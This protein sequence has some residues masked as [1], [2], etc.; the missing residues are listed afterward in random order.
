[1]KN[2][3]RFAALMLALCMLLTACFAFAEDTTATP[4]EDPV[5]VTINGDPIA[6]AEIDATMQILFNNSY[7]SSMTDYQAGVA[8]IV[9][10]YVI[11]KKIAELGLDQYTDE[12]KAA[13]TATAQAEWDAAID[14]Y[15]AYYLSEDTEA[16]RAELAAAANEYYTGQG[17]SVEILAEQAE[18]IAT[19]DKLEAYLKEGKDISVTDDEI[20][21]T[22]EMY[23]AY[24]KESYENNVTM[25]EYYTTYMGQPS[26]YIPAG[27]RGVTQILLDVDDAILADY[28]DKLA[29]YE[30]S[31]SAATAEATA[32][33]DATAE[34]VVAVTLEDVEAAKLAVLESVKEQIDAIQTKFAAGTSF[35]DLIAE[36]NVD[37]GMTDAATLAAGYAVHKDSI[38]YDA[39]FT[40]AAFSDKMIKV[41]DISDPAVS[42]FGVHILYYLRDIPEGNIEITEDITATIKEYLVSQKQNALYAAA[43]EDWTAEFEIVY[44][45]ELIAELSAAEAVAE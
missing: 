13:F 30:E 17:F 33:P 2:L 16:A 5:L 39:N 3:S 20:R 36:Y 23:A 24:D 19:Y 26:W 37:P 40:A 25:Y 45:N 8:Y 15:V 1:M 11:G 44:N 4:D 6:K 41:G 9:Q 21:Q 10:N 35:S 38:M 31:L 28:E 43:I 22:F 42:S 27:Y 32:A 34:P 29:A 14:E 7:I 12:E 18:Q